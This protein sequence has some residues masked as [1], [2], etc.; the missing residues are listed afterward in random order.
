MA[1]EETG[2][3][4]QS[5]TSSRQA[6]RASAAA[7]ERASALQLPKVSL[8]ED[9]EERITALASRNNVLIEY[10]VQNVGG[11][12]EAAARCCCCCCCCR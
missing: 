6:R 3:Q 10:R 11:A 1:S 12:A 2:N 4:G 8:A 9:L 5:S 7:E